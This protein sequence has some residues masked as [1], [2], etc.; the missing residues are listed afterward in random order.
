V[1]AVECNWFEYYLA[2]RP[3]ERLVEVERLRALDEDCIPLLCDHLRDPRLRVRTIAAWTLSEVGDERAVGPLCDALE[4]ADRGVSPWGRWLAT[5]AGIVF[6]AMVTIVG[7]FAMFFA[8][9]IWIGGDGRESVTA[10]WKQNL[11][12]FRGHELFVTAVIEALDR[13]IE[14]SPNPAARRALTPLNRLSEDTVR[15]QPGT[16][17]RAKR[18]A[19]RINLSTLNCHRL[20]VP[21]EASAPSVESLPLPVREG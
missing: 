15:H 17:E 10:D 6:T 13:I 7:V 1:A 3:G 5:C 8:A 16:R 2:P 20:P 11:A 19:H 4:T 9:R 12:T 14:R 18:V 21:S